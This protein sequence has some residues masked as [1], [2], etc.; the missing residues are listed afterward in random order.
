MLLISLNVLSFSCQTTFLRNYRCDEFLENIRYIP[1]H[2]QYKFAIV[3]LQ[4]FVCLCVGETSEQ[5]YTLLMGSSA[6][7]ILLVVIL[8]AAAVV[9]K[10]CCNRNV[11]TTQRC[12]PS[13]RE[14][15]Y[16]Q[17]EG[18]VAI[19]CSDIAMTE[20][21]AYGLQQSSYYKYI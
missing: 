7:I 3:E 1:T 5:E 13:N 20:N 10:I 9:I 2:S 18:T 6:T 21:P 11:N 16:E 12:S 15:I 17:V 8:L 4:L 19:P 14:D